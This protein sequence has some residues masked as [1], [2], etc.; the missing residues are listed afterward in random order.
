MLDD[1]FSATVGFM[2]LSKEKAEELIDYLVDKGEMQREDAR[3]VVDRL[4]EK[5]KEETNKYREQV[6][7]KYDQAVK[8]KFITKE[9]FLRLEGK[10]DELLALLKENRS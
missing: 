1:I 4:V 3:K 2:Y 5:G 10:V 9:D 7:E 6:K 8:E